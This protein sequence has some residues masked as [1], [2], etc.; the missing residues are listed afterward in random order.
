MPKRIIPSPVPPGHK[1]CFKCSTALPVQRFAVDRS[2]ADGRVYACLRC[3]AAQ[4]RKR[5]AVR[6]VLNETFLRTTTL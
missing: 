2:T 4:Q 1:W 5:A 6:A 3:I